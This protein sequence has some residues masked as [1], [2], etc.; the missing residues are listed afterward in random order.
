MAKNFV[1][2]G[3][4]LTLV[5]AAAVSS[6]DFVVKGDTFGVALTNAVIGEEFTLATGRVWDLP[7]D[8]ALAG[9]EGDGVYHDGTALTLDADDG[10]DP[11]VPYLKVGVLAADAVDGN[12][13]CK[14]RLNSSF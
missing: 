3:Q 4:N 1:S 10:G 12:T 14:V 13:S 9:T 11:A 2:Q 5:A 6:G 8:S 7:K